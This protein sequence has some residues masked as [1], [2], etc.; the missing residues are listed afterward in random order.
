MILLFSYKGDVLT[1]VGEAESPRPLW[2]SRDVEGRGSPVSFLLG[3]KKNHTINRITKPDSFH[4]QTSLI[5]TN[6]GM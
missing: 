3:G 5:I 4:Q 6:C 1:E 2:R